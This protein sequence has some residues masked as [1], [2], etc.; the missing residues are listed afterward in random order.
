MI[1]MFPA[2]MAFVAYTLPAAVGLYFAATNL[3]S[4]GQEW[5]I[6]KQLARKA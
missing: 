4:I 1:Y 6:R 3:I 2:V 5:I